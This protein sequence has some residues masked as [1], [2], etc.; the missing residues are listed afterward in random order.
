[1][2]KTISRIIKG[3]ALAAVISIGGSLSAAEAAKDGTI[4]RTAWSFDR[5]EIDWNKGLDPAELNVD[6]ARIEEMKQKGII[7]EMRGWAEYDIEIPAT[8]WYE[9]W[10][11]G[12]GGRD[13]YVDGKLVLYKAIP[14]PLDV[15]GPLGKK[16]NLWLTQGK[17]S[18]RFSEPTFR[19]AYCENSSLPS[20]FELAPA[21]GRPEAAIRS[22]LVGHHVL[23]AGDKLKLRVQGG[24]TGTA[25]RYELEF[26]DLMQPEAPPVPAG[27]VEFAATAEPVTKEI[28]LPCQREGVYKLVTKVDGKPLRPSEFGVSQIAVVDV[29]ARPVEAAERK[30]LVHDIDCVANTDNGKPVDP[31]KYFEANGK[32]R[33]GET[34]AGKYREG[35]D[36][37]GPE[38]EKIQAP[39]EWPATLSGFAY[40]VE[41]PDATSA[42][43]VEVEYPDDDR[44]SVAI[45]V[46]FLDDKGE[47]VGKMI[48]GWETGGVFPL[49][50]RM[51]LHRMVTWASSTR[52][53]IALFSQTIGHRA[54][55][56][57]IRVYRFEGRL[58]QAPA[59]RPDG[60]LFGHWYEEAQTISDMLLNC[61][62]FY[63]N[64]PLVGDFVTLDRWT[65]LARYSGVNAISGFGVGYQTAFWKTRVLD[66][67]FGGSHD[68]TRLAALLCEKNGIKYVPEI[69][70][71]NRA[72]FANLNARSKTPDDLK[73]ISR[74]GQKIGGYNA[75]HPVVQEYWLEAFGEIGD[76]LRDCPAFAGVTVRADPWQFSGT[77]TLPSLSWGYGD[78]MVAELARETGIQ[79]P[80]AADDPE[81]FNVRYKFLT[82]PGMREKW[83][84]WRCARVMDYHQRL[85]DRLRGK[86]RPDLFFGVVG[87]GNCD[88][89]YLVPDNLAERWRG[90]GIDLKALAG[91][92]GVAVMPVGRYGFR[93]TS[94]GDQA[95]YDEFFNPDNV[96]V[97]FGHLRGF[98]AY[99]L[100]HEWYG[101]G[102]LPKLGVILKSKTYCYC[103]Q[104]D[105]AGRHTLEKYA[106]VL[107]EQDSAFLRDGGNSYIFGDPEIWRPWFAEYQALPAKPF[108]RLEAARDPVAVWYLKPGDQSSVISNQLNSSQGSSE[109]TLTDHRSPITDHFLF[110][111]VNRERL[112]VTITLTL[113]DAGE[114]RSLTSGA[115][116]RME[117]GAL[118]LELAPYELRAFRCAAGAQIAT[119]KTDV[120]AELTE[121]VKR[122][123]AFAQEL[124][125]QVSVGGLREGALTKPELE[126]VRKGVT[127][128]WTAFQ[129]GHSSRARTALCA[130]PL[131]HA[132][133]KLGMMP[134]AQVTTRFPDRLTAVK[135]GFY[136]HGEPVLKAGEIAKLCAAD[137]KVERVDSATINPDW[138]GEELL[139]LRDGA[140]TFELDVP[141]D[142]PYSLVLGHAAEERGVG[143]VTLNGKS[144]PLPV[145][146]INAR[147]PEQTVFPPVTLKAGKARVTVRRDGAFGLYGVKWLPSWRPMPSAVW[148]TTGPFKSFWRHGL[149][150]WYSGIS[151][152]FETV[153][154][155]E[156]NRGL[157]AVYDVPAELVSRDQRRFG[158]SFDDDGSPDVRLG[159]LDMDHGK[160][161]MKIGV[162]CKVRTGSAANDFSFAQTTIISPDDRTVRLA[163]SLD[164]WAEIWL[165]G[166]KVISEMSEEKK[167]MYGCQFC[168]HEPLYATI[169]LKKGANPMFV[170]QQ[171]G[172]LGSG[173]LFWVSDQP[174]L[175][176]RARP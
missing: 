111:A 157:S 64:G 156:T 5:S 102:P 158:W 27:A 151:K 7:K 15:K 18:L 42:Y 68:A 13:L 117:Q 123:L 121:F 139:M 101:G 167:E 59:G 140:L 37:T 132:Y 154:P 107:A 67:L 88:T 80:G 163:V 4:R 106:A 143:T 75:T 34:P 66:G 33:V 135:D 150:P 28:E 65:Q 8:G 97:G 128:A 70:G 76:L 55:A 114:V 94:V 40:E 175:E 146:T 87:D 61:R 129:Q 147:T 141:A 62:S 136:K 54:A 113:A 74:H 17:R 85:R 118:R 119:A 153:Y 159:P 24:G 82:T 124:L 162:N 9:I 21:Q 38:V 98:A 89:S 10:Q 155:P 81:R 149:E 73:S 6:A 138:R 44:R 49:S 173:F 50:N 169:K 130:A 91:M 109:T 84:A 127:E 115:V 41:L 72:M 152:G 161:R 145:T 142:G 71:G 25:I 45:P 32:T 47:G 22:E 29:K 26:V 144:L 126:E 171:G 168:G 58:P 176:F 164:F 52:M 160:V 2:R 60:R 78:W 134:E 56:S 103:T 92:P 86:D 99:M 83:E 104:V 105:G 53:N 122:R 108:T 35:N 79:V 43:L 100:Y 116:Q 46:T 11:Q 120:P 95:T 36:C 93:N 125:G 19:D 133:V 137:A 1:M 165:N 48:K 20:A 148:A 63:K 170:K 51:S 39:A 14:A 112:P 131:M 30:T 77:F 174:D 3:A 110:Y 69:F 166:E 172:S 23:R 96:A 57:R 90:I 31:A 16:A 12:N